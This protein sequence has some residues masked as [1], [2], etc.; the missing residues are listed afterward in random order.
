MTAFIYLKVAFFNTEFKMSDTKFTE[1]KQQ[2][3]ICDLRNSVTLLLCYS[4]TL[5]L[6]YSVLEIST[7]K[8]KEE[9]FQ[10]RRY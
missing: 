3:K 5:L 2:S 8:F 9:N 4:V 1:E 6:C 10:I 7:T